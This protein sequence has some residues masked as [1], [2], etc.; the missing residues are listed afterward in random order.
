MHQT[1][2]VT[3]QLIII[4]NLE[5]FLNFHTY[6]YLRPLSWLRIVHSGD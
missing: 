1:T 2:Q 5:L 3:Q 6:L 4:L